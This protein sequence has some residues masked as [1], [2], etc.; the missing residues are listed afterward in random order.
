MASLIFRTRQRA[1]RPLA[2][3]LIWLLVAA[4]S[5]SADA[6]RSGKISLHLGVYPPRLKTDVKITEPSGNR[7][8]D[9]GEKGEVLAT[10]KNEGSGDAFG[11]Q[12]AILALSRP[13]GISFPTSLN[14]GTIRAGAEKTVSIPITADQGVE[15]G[16]C[17]I[18]LRFREEMGFDADPVTLSFA[19]RQF[20]PPDLQV[21]D[22]GIHDFSQNGKIEPGETVE[23]VVRIMNK[24]GAKAESVRAEVTVGENVFVLPDSKTEFDLGDMASFEYKDI[25][26]TLVTNKR[27]ET[28]TVPVTVKL[29]TTR[30]QDSRETE[31]KQ[32]VL[33][34]PEKP[35]TV[36]VLSGEEEDQRPREDLGVPTLSVDVD[37]NVPELKRENKFGI[38]VIIG[39]KDYRSRD[40]PPVDYAIRDAAVVKEYAEKTLGYRPGNIIY[41]ENATQAN[42]RAIFGS[43][44]DHRGKLY[45]YVRPGRSDVF[46]YY[47]GHGAP[48]PSGPTGYFVPVDCDPSQVRLNGYSLEN[49]SK[50]LAKIPAKSVTVVLDA[51]FSGGSERGMLLRNASPVY[52]DIGNPLAVLKNAVVFTSS[53]G[54]QISSW[55]PQKR[56]GLFT[57]FFLKGLQ[58]E[59][60]KNR[61]GRIDADEL[62]A[63]VQEEVSYMARRLAGRDQN[64]QLIGN[65][66][67]AI[68]TLR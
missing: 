26:F 37:L 58:G 66:D 20:I 49:F 40:V 29:Q 59:A 39:N 7:I 16:S 34:R 10:I 24:G 44:T 45:N 28:D 12:I 64:P 47:S 23:V 22:V 19:T 42:F 63:F 15:T 61:N 35:Q 46:I 38:A 54:D 67:S 21:A 60:D 14:V 13:K 4:F 27:I 5:F 18:E 3:L 6:A 30:S 68:V 25:A 1:V 2:C 41:V 56:H 33:N 31:L 55:Y 48:D 9:A 36:I 17:K 65:R 11:V 32:L 51:C 57:Y 53:S 52:F 8:F 62:F 50:N 43:E